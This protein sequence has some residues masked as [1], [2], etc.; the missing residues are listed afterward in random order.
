M[1]QDRIRALHR[2]LMKQAC[3]VVPMARMCEFLVTGL[4]S[5]NSK[6]RVECIEVWTAVLLLTPRIAVQHCC[7]SSAD[8]RLFAKRLHFTSELP[9]T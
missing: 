4:A 5:R 6:T 3:G 2:D 7:L 9:A 8:R 1:P